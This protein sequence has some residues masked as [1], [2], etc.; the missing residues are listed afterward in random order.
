MLFALWFAVPIVFWCA[1]SALTRGRL[2]RHLAF[3][4]YV[5]YFYLIYAGSFTVYSTERE[6][7]LWY[8]AN[9][10]LYPLISLLGLLTATLFVDN[11]LLP[12]IELRARRRDSIITLC[13]VAAFLGVYAVYLS[14]PGTV[15]PLWLLITS[16]DR[17]A[18]YV[19]R[20]VA[21]KGYGAVGVPGFI[22]WFPRILIDYYSAFV[23]AFAYYMFRRRP[24]FLLKMT[25][26][27]GALLL[28]TLETTQKYP[29]MKLCGVL[30]LCVYNAK[31]T[32]T[33]WT[34][35]VYGVVACSVLIWISGAVYAIVSGSYYLKLEGHGF[36]SGVV[37][38]MNFGIAMLKNRAIG[39]ETEALHVTYVMVP[40]Y[41]PYFLGR[42]LDNPH[43]IFPYTHVVFPYLVSDF[44]KLAPA[45]TQGSS[46]TVYFGELYANFGNGLTWLSMFL[47]GFALQ[48]MNA[49]LDAD[50]ARYRTPFCI[51]FFYMIMMYLGDFS[52]G[53][54]VPYVDPRV[55]FFV[56]LYVASKMSVRWRAPARARR[57]QTALQRS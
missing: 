28:M 14:W 50:I 34:G 53:L 40:D 52:L 13:A 57:F 15:S 10:M 19:A 17:D 33:T 31:L 51:A 21:T 2:P 48:L 54:N 35:V 5:I 45:G 16:Q 4:H 18:A 47:F 39:A 46:P 27:F 30:A 38:I 7:N 12:A 49:K 3:A 9:V 37:S 22:T 25:L 29:A 32:R 8:L 24:L 23:L 36:G 11:T 42:T 56:L 6:H 44:Y 55:W 26:V 20:Y 43:G 41:Y 1:Y